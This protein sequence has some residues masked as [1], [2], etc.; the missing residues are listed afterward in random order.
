MEDEGVI[1]YDSKFQYVNNVVFPTVYDGD[2]HFVSVLANGNV[3][4]QGIVRL[5]E[6][7][8]N[9]DLLQGVAK[10]DIVTM[11][12]NAKRNSWKEVSGY[13]KTYL[14]SAQMVDED[15]YYQKCDNVVAYQ[16]IK[17]GKIDTS[18]SYIATLSNKGKLGTPWFKNENLDITYIT[19]NGDKVY[20][21]GT[22]I[23]GEMHIKI[24]KGNKLRASITESKIQAYLPSY[25]YLDNKGVIRSFT[26]LEYSY[27]AKADGYE[28][29][30]DYVFKN[31]TQYAIFN[32]DSKSMR[33]V[34]GIESTND[35]AR[36]NGLIKLTTD[37]D[38]IYYFNQKD[39]NSV[40]NI[41]LN[42]QQTLGCLIYNVGTGGAITSAYA[43]FTLSK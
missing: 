23:L 12:Y 11:L 42:G 40:Y 43:T 20:L 19:L 27:D 29:V 30:S 13:T 6:E 16:E 17:D 18:K 25:F 33:D 34:A 32:T 24:Y 3:M 2:P 38:Y 28:Y 31:A 1:L 36:N 4:M 21:Y 5:P 37:G 7:K 26:D 14:V 35:I 41:D 9:Y 10:Y 15:S 8:K 22:D 39:G